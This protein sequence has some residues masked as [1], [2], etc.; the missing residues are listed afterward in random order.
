MKT[1]FPILIFFLVAS[2]SEST[3]T[4][5]PTNDET[6]SSQNSIESEVP[7][8]VKRDSAESLRSYTDRLK[9][10]KGNWFKVEYPSQFQASPLSPIEK[11]NDYE[12]VA[13]DEATFV[14]PDGSIEFFV[15]SPLW[16]G[17]PNNYLQKR[18]NEKIISDKTEKGDG[19]DPFST[20][21]HWVTFEDVDGKYTRAYHSL[22]TE[23]THHVF[24]VKYTNRKMYEVYK[25][26]YLAF[27]KSLEQYAD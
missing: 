18:A 6:S 20:T 19:S 23:S 22:R 25:A 5:T 21:H 26:A 8:R 12:F 1:L 15:Y 11:T 24:G 14:S 17:N 4:D 27:K 10:F 2:C 9:D 13:T 7:E 16:S 3:E